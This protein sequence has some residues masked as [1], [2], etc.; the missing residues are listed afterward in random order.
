MNFMRVDGSLVKVF[1]DEKMPESVIHSVDASMDVKRPS[2]NSLEMKKPI[3]IQQID[4][5]SMNS[6]SPSRSP[7]NIQ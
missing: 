3:V 6:F 5:T 4:K 1:E 2:R 7:T